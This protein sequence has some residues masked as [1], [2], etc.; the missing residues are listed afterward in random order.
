M[1]A[2][3][4]W[5]WR[6]GWRSLR[7]GRGLRSRRDSAGAARSSSATARSRSRAPSAG[8]DS[9]RGWPARTSRLDRSARRA[10]G[11]RPR[12]RPGSKAGDRSSAR[13]P[14]TRPSSRPFPGPP[15]RTAR[16]CASAG[17]RRSSSTGRGW[18]RTRPSESPRG[19]T[20]RRS[21]ALDS[22]SRAGR[23]PGTRR[24]S[25]RSRRGRRTD[26]VEE[27]VAEARAVAVGEVAV[28]V[29]AALDSASG[30]AC[31]PRPRREPRG[32]AESPL[33]RSLRREPATGRPSPR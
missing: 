28:V 12:T 3:S 25:P 16:R 18:A 1:R 15:S 22:A 29:E 8:V 24:L 20:R 7:R 30:R 2:P 27:E 21:P 13:R 10:A 6:H 5:G 9:G 33:Q 32:G 14:P 31:S 17:R 4:P 11:R 19:P 26:S 23:P